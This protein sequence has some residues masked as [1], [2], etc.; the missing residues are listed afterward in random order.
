MEENTPSSSSSK[1]EVLS[2]LNRRVHQ[3]IDLEEFLQEAA[4]QIALAMNAAR[5]TIYFLDKKR[6]ELWSK[7]A[8]LEEISEIRLKLGQGVAGHV[9]ES[10]ETIN[11][12]ASYSDKRFYAGIDQQTGF[13]TLSQLAAPIW[14][15][16]GEILGV[17]QILNKQDGIFTRED[18]QF[19]EILC[20]QFALLIEN[21]SL[22][23]MMKVTR[24]KN[25]R[26]FPLASRY[27]NIIGTSLDMQKVFSLIGKIAP[28]AITVLIRGES[29][30]GKEMVAR[31]IH[32]NSPRKDKPFVKIDCIA[33]PETLLENELFG[34]EKGAYT[35]A[36]SRMAGKIEAAKDGTL[37]IDEIGDMPLSM[38]GKLLRI[39]QDRQYEPLGTTQSLEVKARILC[40]T[41]Q[42]LEKLLQEQKFRSDLYFRIK[43]AQIFLP[44]L[45]QRQ[46]ADIIALAEYF[47]E[48]FNRQY[49]KK[50][51]G[52]SKES[53]TI[54][55]EYNWP[56]NVRE[57]EN[58]IESAV[59]LN[60][61]ICI[62]P[63]S[64]CLSPS[65]IPIPTIEQENLSLEEMEKR[66]ILHVLQ[67]TQ[68]NKSK[69][70]E[71]LKI[72]RNT[73]LRKLE[74]YGLAGKTS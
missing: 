13:K 63:E 14:D 58:A 3:G 69:A 36:I 41:N 68:G 49:Q 51:Q 30:T 35:G 16:N 40:A 2:M 73:L 57:M 48:K 37:F 39:L 4:D 54:L 31:A 45:R 26:T 21:T 64:L 61:G 60:E 10:G 72:G 53:L 19:L 56:G 71:I 18:E 38:Q 17:V 74:E 32:L 43:V 25:T 55:T 52:F 12:P 7:I 59:V 33:L 50:I 5:V 9:A 42:N 23:Q 44:P 24:L 46:S 62:T 11:I 70:A 22:Y 67:K 29:G 47:L 1:L 65:I 27:N 6:Q 15:K 28:T 20:P 66:H 8:H 34:H